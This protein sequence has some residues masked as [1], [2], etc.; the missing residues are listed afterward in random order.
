MSNV[1]GMTK[2]KERKA[3]VR[4]SFIILERGFVSALVIRAS[5]FSIHLP[6]FNERVWN[7]FQETRRA[8]ENVAIAG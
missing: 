3:R 8:L 1:E 4:C 6:V 7:L 5:S 2:A